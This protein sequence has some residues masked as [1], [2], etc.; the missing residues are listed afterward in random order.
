MTSIPVNL[1]Y[2]PTHTWVELMDDDSVRVGIT[3][4]GQQQLGE[5]VYVE[6]PET[7]RNYAAGEECA[8]IESIKTAVDVCCPLG[9][10][11]TAINH[12]LGDN[13]VLINSDV[14]DDG[15]LFLLVPDDLADLDE[16]LDSDAYAEQIEEA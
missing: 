2:N 11:I 1:R 5:I 7:D 3:D 14:Y 4:F 9:G 6:L 12:A 8:V 15:W 16:L 10:E 13:P